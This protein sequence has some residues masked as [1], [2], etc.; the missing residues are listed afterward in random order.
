MEENNLELENLFE[1]M[2][3]CIS[4]NA[5]QKI[6]SPMIYSMVEKGNF[7][8]N[9]ESGQDKKL[10]KDIENILDK[11]K[12]DEGREI[13]VKYKKESKEQK[14]LNL[15]CQHP[16][17]LKYFVKYHT[18][19]DGDGWKPFFYP[20]NNTK[21][22]DRPIV[23]L[24]YALLEHARNTTI[25]IS[26]SLY[27]RKG[28]NGEIS[29]LSKVGKEGV[30]L[31]L[32]YNEE[33][34]IFEPVEMIRSDAIIHEKLALRDLRD[35]LKLSPENIRVIHHLSQYGDIKARNKFLSWLVLVMC[36]HIICRLKTMKMEGI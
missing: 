34:Q 9:T 32:L 30:T 7:F 19:G 11:I 12:Q 35:A 18:E 28:K 5:F 36:M 2:N 24:L 1:I 33:A 16:D 15:L 31:N 8:I 29:L 22:P 17:M 20:L 26:V 6:I 21:M 25:K 3:D 4:G 14:E 27:E 23:P 13:D 10:K